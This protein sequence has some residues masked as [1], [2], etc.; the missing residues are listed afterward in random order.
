[1]WKRERGNVLKAWLFVQFP[2]SRNKIVAKA[3]Q[4]P[5]K[6][7]WYSGH[8][9][10]NGPLDIRTLSHDLNTG[11]VYIVLRCTL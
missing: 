4:N 1:M 5:N 3:I 2:I 8:G 6:I 11:L 10:K 9:L 7:V